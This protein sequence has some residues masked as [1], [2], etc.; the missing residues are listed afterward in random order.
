[1]PSKK[2]PPT[3]ASLDLDPVNNL[4]A[5]LQAAAVD[6]RLTMAGLDHAC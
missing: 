1:M 3:L 4:P 6:A 5:V 2:K